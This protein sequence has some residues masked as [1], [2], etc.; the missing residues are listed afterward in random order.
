MAECEWCGETKESL[1]KDLKD[2]IDYMVTTKINFFNLMTIDDH[3][4]S[5]GICCS[6]CLAQWFIEDPEV[7]VMHI[8]K[9][10]EDRLPGGT[11]KVEAN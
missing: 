8:E 1:E 2:N 4:V 10:V 9:Y 7:D 3:T 6:N 11:G 5:R